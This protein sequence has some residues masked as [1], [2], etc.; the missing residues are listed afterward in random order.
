MSLLP[1]TRYRLVARRHV[2]FRLPTNVIAPQASLLVTR[3]G[4][5]RYVAHQ[6]NNIVAISVSPSRF[7]AALSEVHSSALPIVLSRISCIVHMHYRRY[8]FQ[9]RRLSDSKP[10]SPNLRACQRLDRP[11]S[12]HCGAFIA[13]VIEE[14]RSKPE[15]RIFASKHLDLVSTFHVCNDRPELVYAQE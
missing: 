15:D 4:R 14:A 13:H 2:G 3:V 9:P 5:I 7:T 12:G 8:R 1:P 10:R 6:D 11:C